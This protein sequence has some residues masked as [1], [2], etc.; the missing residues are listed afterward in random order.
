VNLQVNGKSATLET[1]T[2]VEDLLHALQLDPRGVA[3]AINHRV[4]PR[5]AIPEQGLKEADRVEIIR[6]VGGG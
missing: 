4:V 1:G 5:S 3:V 6:A 2:T